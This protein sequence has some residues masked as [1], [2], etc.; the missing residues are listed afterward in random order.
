M[1]SCTIVGENGCIS[2]LDLSV[3]CLISIETEEAWV[4]QYHWNVL[5]AVAEMM[6]MMKMM[7]EGK[8]EAWGP[9]GRLL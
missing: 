6:R 9:L 1:K 8:I 2:G 7:L 5:K 3:A 4:E